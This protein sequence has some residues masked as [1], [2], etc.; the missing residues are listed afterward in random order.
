VLINEAVMVKYIDG[1][2]RIGTY[3]FG[4]IDKS[5]NTHIEIVT[6]PVTLIM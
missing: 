4:V 2:D 3:E 5:G 1:P 6:E